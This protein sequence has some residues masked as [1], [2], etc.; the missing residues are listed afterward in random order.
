MTTILALRVEGLGKGI[1]GTGTDGLYRWALEQPFVNDSSGVY[2]SGALV[3]L[4]DEI[5]F[6]CDFRA[7]RSSVGGLT[8]QLLAFVE[9]APLQ[10]EQAFYTQRP[11]VIAKLLE[12]LSSGTGTSTLYTD[13]PGLTGRTLILGNEA[14]YMESEDSSSTYTA[15]RGVL[16]TRAAIHGDPGGEIRG[17]DDDEIFDA[18]DGPILRGRRVELIEVDS[19]GDYADEVVLWTGVIDEISHPTPNVIEIG[20]TSALDHLRDRRLCESLWRGR[21]FSHDA[22]TALG[23]SGGAGYIRV[24]GTNSYDAR[25]LYAWGDKTAVLSAPPGARPDSPITIDSERSTLLYADSALIDWNDEPPQEV[26]QFF[27]TA[28]QAPDLG[29]GRRLSNNLATLTLQIL[30]TTPLGTNYDSAGGATNYDLGDANIGAGVDWELVDVEG[31]ERARRRLGDLLRVDAVHL[32]AE[33]KPVE[34]L[35]WLSSLWRPYGGVLTGGSGGLITVALFADSTEA[36][37]VATSINVDD[38]A[39]R[40]EPSQRRRLSDAIDSITIAYAD[41]PGVDPIVDT[42][43]DVFNRRR[44]LKAPST[45]REELDLLGCDDRQLVLDLGAAYIQRYN[46]PIPESTLS[47]LGQTDLWPGDLCRVTLGM[48]SGRDVETPVSGEIHLV[49]GRRYVRKGGNR[50]TYRLLAVSQIYSNRGA[51]A[52]S[53]QVTSWDSGTSTVTCDA[54][55]YTTGDGPFSTDVE[56]FSTFGTADLMILDAGDLS[57]KAT[58][59]S[60]SY[61]TNTITLTGLGGYTPVAGDI[62]VLRDYPN[63]GAGDEFEVY[64]V[65]SDL[66]GEYEGGDGYDWGY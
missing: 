27:S 49:T 56:A 32:G 60:S 48:L 41:R 52:P 59:S 9:D 6:E 45:S 13:T 47:L 4:P 2:V 17:Q 18:D 55:A 35:A 30:T 28:P 7:G 34:A 50:V 37:S 64:A 26:W 12:G 53:V 33:G 23:G 57:V 3:G 66:N 24:G 43:N 62:L 25:A 65:I 16:G 29:T 15:T 22:P 10:P 20:C 5:G 58:C 54:N 19:D 31:I 36:G 46:V 1:Y 8:F 40:V 42:F 21:R 63:Q 44:Q 39:E 11:L 14:L 51:W 61:G 38:I